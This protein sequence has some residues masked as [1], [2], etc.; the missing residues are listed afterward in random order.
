M[1]WFKHVKGNEFKPVQITDRPGRIAGGTFKPGRTAQ[2]VVAPGDLNGPI[3]FYEC[4][5]NPEN[6]ADWNS[7][8]LLDREMIH[9]HTLAIADVNSDGN[10]DIFS[11]EMAKWERGDAVQNPKATA[12][13]WYGDG[14]GGFQRTVFQ[15]GF[16]FHEARLADLDGDG[17]IDVLS[18][19][20]T[21]NAPRIDVWLQTA[22]EKSA[23]L[24][25]P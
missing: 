15:E 11:G 23:L 19:P 7:R 6:P 17:R 8:D 9:G 24:P 10:L 1:W 2:I 4:G 16:G 3:R 21:W 18:K 20:Y 22:S 25:Q 14:Q 12:W 13:I 5:G